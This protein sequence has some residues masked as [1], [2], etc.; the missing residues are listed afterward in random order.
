MKYP[1]TYH[2]PYSPCATKDDKKLGR[3]TGFLNWFNYYKGK[4]IVISEKLDGENTCFSKKD[5]Y[6]V[7]MVLQVVHLGHG[8]FGILQMGFIGKYKDL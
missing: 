3:K 5:V 1:L 7:V 4:E 2:L 6:A 8:I